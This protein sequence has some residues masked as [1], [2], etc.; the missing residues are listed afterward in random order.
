[1]FLQTGE[2]KLLGHLNWKGYILLKKL[3]QDWKSN[4]RFESIQFGVVKSEME[5]LVPGVRPT[6]SKLIGQ[7][8]WVI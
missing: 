7:A 2:E 1:M 3:N 6:I 5:E 4:V 8:N